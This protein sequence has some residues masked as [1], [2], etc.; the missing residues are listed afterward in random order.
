MLFGEGGL[1]G[2]LLGEGTFASLLLRGEGVLA[3]LFQ[4]EVVLV[5]LLFGVG[6]FA[7][8][9]FRGAVSGLG[10]DVVHLRG[11]GWWFSEFG[12]RGVSWW[13]SGFGLRAHYA[14]GYGKSS[15]LFAWRQGDVPPCAGHVV[16]GLFVVKE[17]LVCFVV[18]ARPPC[19]YFCFVYFAP[20]SLISLSSAGS[21]VSLLLWI[22]IVR[23]R[24]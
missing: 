18:V 11:V 12:W 16:A 23:A 4:D 24:F 7:G 19:I 20:V 21:Q 1:A 17:G 2:R 3:G 14:L 10:S 15:G 6:V 8:L 13:L 22:E 9:F 5:A